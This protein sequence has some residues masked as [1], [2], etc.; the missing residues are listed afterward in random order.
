MAGEEV[1]SMNMKTDF[2]L[3]TWIN[4][5]GKIWQKF[6]KGG[7]KHSCGDESWFT[8]KKLLKD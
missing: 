1:E 4:K 7:E 6:Q 2:W 8:F 5:Q 3:V